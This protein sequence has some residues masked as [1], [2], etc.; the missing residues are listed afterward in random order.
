VVHHDA[1]AVDPQVAGPHHAAVVGRVHGRVP[2]VGEIEAQVHLLV[3]LFAVIHVIAHVGEV[4]L[5]FAPVGNGPFHSIFLFGLEAQVGELLIVLAAQVAVDFEEAGQQIGTRGEVPSG[6]TELTSVAISA[7][8][9]GKSRA[10]NFF[11]LSG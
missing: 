9:D 6:S 8:L 11:G 5:F 7:S 2:D 1:I 4:G 10:R 3:H